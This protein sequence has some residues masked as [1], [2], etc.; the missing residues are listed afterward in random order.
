[1][2]VLGLI[3]TIGFVLLMVLAAWVALRV[4][5]KLLCVFGRLVPLTVLGV[6][7][8]FGGV[9]LFGTPAEHRVSFTVDN[10]GIESG[11]PH[12]QGIVIERDLSSAAHG[13][14]KNWRI[15]RDFKT[16]RVPKWMLISLGTI[17]IICGAMLAGR[18]R[19]GPKAITAATVLGIGAILFSVV[20]FFSSP[21]PRAS[22]SAVHDRVIKVARS[23]RAA[24]SSSAR[25]PSSSARA[26]SAD[27]DSSVPRHPKKP[28]RPPR[29]KRPAS[30][31]DRRA[32]SDDDLL[33]ELPKRAGEIPVEVEL[34]AEPAKPADASAPPAPPLSEAGAEAPP[35]ALS[36]TE[37]ATA[38]EKA[39]VPEKAPTAD[40]AR[41]AEQPQPTDAAKPAEQPPAAE[42]LQ[43]SDQPQPA[44][45]STPSEVSAPIQQS[46]PAA[47]PKPVVEQPLAAHPTP[48]PALAGGVEAT[49][50]QSV[51]TIA[52]EAR[53]ERPAWV[54][55]PSHFVSSNS[56]YAV[57]IK[58]GP[59]A[60]VPECQRELD[61]EMKRAAD[62]YINE[63]LGDDHAAELVAISLDYL[64][65]NV[66]KAEYDEVLHSES[67]GPM[68]QI[69][70]Q[71][72]FDPAAQN[73]FR[74]VRH[75]ALVTDRLWFA[76]TG[77]ALVLALLGT[78][79]GY[80]KLDLRSQ[81]ANK[82]RLQLAATLVALILAAGTLL[83]RWAVPF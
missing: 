58:S 62:Q 28:K 42:P 52:L 8:I 40:E 20:S 21:T 25:A 71:L 79:Y 32:E 31:P 43:S 69:H 15:Q 53:K 10:D 61:R 41:P 48:T 17:L 65:Q 77:A 13:M 56:A 57:S 11:S 34:A 16:G 73:D 78:F 55:A 44:A 35:V 63:L 82:S 49:S 50:A 54:D 64:K 80:L 60:S 6:A 27:D 23:E 22:N 66:K 72:E 12:D 39:P 74:H 1:M 24:A 51:A 76:G 47:P 83:V 26:P 4:G 7:A 36:P 45:Q 75:D 33:A 2:L 30:R 29:A 38:P 81:G 37:P 46:Q 5:G 70:A 3:S 18:G 9:A 59:W 67:V 68:H 14:H 19:T